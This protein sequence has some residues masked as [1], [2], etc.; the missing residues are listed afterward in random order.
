M[1][2]ERTNLSVLVLASSENAFRRWKLTTN[3]GYVR[4][5]YL[6][7]PSQLAGRSP[8]NT[9]LVF[10]DD[11]EKNSNYTVNMHTYLFMRGFTLP[12]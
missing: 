8:D 5:T 1:K 10:L 11:W 6:G 3:H 9:Q 2:K 7:H 12:T 4:P